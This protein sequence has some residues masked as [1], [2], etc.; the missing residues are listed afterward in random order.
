[1]TSTVKYPSILSTY[2]AGPLT[3]AEEICAI[4]RT[5]NSALFDA[6]I[7]YTARL[8]EALLRHGAVQCGFPYADLRKDEQLPAIERFFQ[9]YYLLLRP[10]A[11]YV[12]AL[13][14]L[15][16]CC[17][18]ASRALTFE[19]AAFAIV[20]LEAFLNWYMDAVD[21]HTCERGNDDPQTVSLSCDERLR[22]VAQKIV[23]PGVFDFIERENL[24]GLLERSPSIIALAAEQLI[25]IAID[26]QG[27]EEANV[28]LEIAEERFPERPEAIRFIQLRALYYSRKRMPEKAIE[29]LL[30]LSGKMKDYY[31]VETAGILAGA[32]KQLNDQSSLCEAHRIYLEAWETYSQRQNAY[33]GINAAAT[34]LW[35]GE[36]ARA[37]RIAEDVRNLLLRREDAL[38]R[39]RPGQ[40]SSLDYYD[41]VTLAEAYLITGDYDTAKL[42]YQRAFERW[43]DEQGRIKKTKEQAERHLHLRN[44]SDDPTQFWR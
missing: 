26:E 10:T 8:Q 35:I 39:I 31:D 4:E 19:D 36:R 32:Y 15:G 30:T 29:H 18:H 14:W 27:F 24:Y 3:V 5:Y 1:M 42:R 37:R 2:H 23:E 16:N 40:G 20:Y 12:D 9:N 43:P 7:F 6:T 22:V 28:V 13:R 33:P 21:K 38:A 11:Q 44:V 34:A 17:R 25:D 41:Q